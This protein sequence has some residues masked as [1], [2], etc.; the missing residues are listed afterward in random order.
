MKI[1]I[2]ASALALALAACGG[3]GSKEATGADGGAGSATV[4]VKAFQFKPNPAQIR[5]RSRVMWVNGDD[6]THTITAG[7]PD[8][9]SPGFDGKLEGPGAQFSHAFREPGTYPYF[10]SVHTSMTG[11][12]TVA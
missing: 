1:A 5:A 4:T 8:E 2:S 3:G 10:C 9:K 7:A 12:V 6:T 11:E